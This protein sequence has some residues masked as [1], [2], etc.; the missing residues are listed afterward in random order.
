MSWRGTFDD[1]LDA[2]ID[3]MR[4]GD[5]VEAV[6]AR[7]PRHAAALRPLLE[8]ASWADPVKE[9]APPSPR[10]GENFSRIDAALGRARWERDQGAEGRRLNRAPWWQRRV[11]LAS[12][13]L[14]AGVLVFALL[15]AGGAAAATLAVTTDL[16]DRVAE[17]VET[18][19]PSWAH[20]VIPGGSGDVDGDAAG[21]T[22]GS[23]TASPATSTAT[24]ASPAT[25]TEPPASPTAHGPQAVTLAGTVTNIRGS[26]FELVAEDGTYKVQIDANT[27]V[28]GVL[29]EG[30][31]ATVDGELTGNDRVHATS[32]EVAAPT[33]GL[34]PPPA[35]SAETPGPGDR[36]PPGQ[37]EETTTPPGQSEGVKTPPGPP[38]KTKTPGP[39]ATPP[40]Q[41]G[42]NGNGGGG[43]G[44][45]G[46][47]GGGGGN[48]N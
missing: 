24:T 17:K 11:A 21:D 30:S 36:T 6:L 14:P 25:G 35:S 43:G 20:G 18:I 47:G 27:T 44:G 41:G 33:P 3:A 26:T 7:Y 37:A 5:T 40:G 23:P 45:G 19:T 39:P 10:L 4:S 1:A 15:G 31:A 12:L 38:E 42:A 48:G 8:T 9:Y 22:P 2:A 46:S 28:N 16:P 13:S 29:A 32:I 34:D